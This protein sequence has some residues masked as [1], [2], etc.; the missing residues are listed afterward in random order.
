MAVKRPD[1]R[2][3]RPA[4]TEKGREDQLISLAVDLAE[5]QIIEG[6]ASSQ[7]ITHFL[8]LGSSREKLEQERLRGENEVLKAK[9]EAMASAKRIEELYSEALSAMK[10]YAGQDPLEEDFDER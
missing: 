2:K 8:K 3:R 9:V 6:T 4:N 7:V 10:A 5:K 1:R